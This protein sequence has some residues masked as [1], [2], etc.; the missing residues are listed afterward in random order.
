MLTEESYYTALCIYAGAGVL[1]CVLL[2]LWLRRRWAPFWVALVTLL[3]AALLLTPAYPAA[4]VDTFAPAIL[5][6]GFSLLTDG[7]EGALL[8]TR[9]LAVMVGLA[10]GLALLLQVALF[11]RQRRRSRPAPAV[12]RTG[13]DAA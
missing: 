11:R 1:V 12:P 13:A 2:W 5:V 7:G 4:D 8:A 6:L 9:P 3:S 10:C